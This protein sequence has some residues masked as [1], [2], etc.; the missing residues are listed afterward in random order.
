MNL[1]AM[2]LTPE[3]LTALAFAPFGTVIDALPSSVDTGTD[4]INAGSAA[5]TEAVRALDLVRD[6]GRAVLALYQARAR[7]FPFEAVVLERHRLS[8]QVFLPL[9][10]ALR[11]VLLVAPAGPAP[12]ASALR[13]FITTGAQGVRI[14]AGTWHHPLL[15]LQDGTWAVIE[16]RALDGS[17]DCDV[18]PLPRPVWIEPGR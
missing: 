14:G 16:R 11:C 8:D 5:R 7:T 12:A 15:A 2:N 1:H 6:D 13:A 18:A 9:G 3:P 10:A 17:V 4:L